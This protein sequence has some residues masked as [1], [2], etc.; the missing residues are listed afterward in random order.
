[1]DLARGETALTLAQARVLH[2]HAQGLAGPP[3]RRARPEDVVAAIARMRLLQIDTIHVVARSPYLVLFSRLGAYD[4]AWLDAALA[5]G[6]IFETWAHEA[7]FAPIDALALHAADAD[8]PARHWALRNAHRMRDA[9]P[10]AMAALLAHVRAHGEVRSSDFARET[11]AAG[12]WDW[13]LE[14]RCMEAWFALGALMVARRERFQRVYDLRER[15]LAHA[16]VTVPPA[17]DPAARRRRMIV[18]AVRALG[19]APARWIAD[20]FRIAPRIGDAELEP[21]CGAGLLRPVEV[22]GWR[23]PGYVHRDHADG[24]ADAAAGRLRARHTTLLSP[25][26]PV[27]WDRARA[28]AL[29]GFDY[30]IECYVPAPKRRYGYFV[31]PILRRG[32]LV[33]RLD[34]K[35]HRAEGVFEVKGLWLEP[36][37]RV[38]AALAADL[39]AALRRCADW[40]GTP[41][42]RV[43]RSEPAALLPALRAAL[44]ARTG[45]GSDP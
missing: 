28:A 44:A 29:F 17:L 41:A 6:A 8:A 3:R 36:G 33:G 35:A 10:Q 37:V 32:A 16:G 13:K 5:D 31:L 2:L 12:W 43:R 14:K 40:H 11:S 15:V 24:L 4:P 38:S 34:A 7:C 18:D 39:A 23:H 1:M 20:Y 25:F 45:A 19:I 30:R 9:H 42:V 26:D 21:L 22:E 27:V